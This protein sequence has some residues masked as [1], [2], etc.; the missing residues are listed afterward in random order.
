[1]LIRKSWFIFLL[2]SELKAAGNGSMNFFQG[3]NESPSWIKDALICWKAFSW[4][5]SRLVQLTRGVTV[6]WLLWKGKLLLTA[7]ATSKSLQSRPTLCDPV[8]GI[9]QAR[10]LEWVAVSFSNA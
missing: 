9:L 6:G 4:C 8:P 5:F 10:T 2:V 7:A 3:Q 1:M